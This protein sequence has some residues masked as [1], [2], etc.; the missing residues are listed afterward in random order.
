MFYDSDEI[1][2]DGIRFAKYLYIGITVMLKAVT[3]DLFAFGWEKLESH[4]ALQGAL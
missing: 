2:R 3:K 1:I 4:G